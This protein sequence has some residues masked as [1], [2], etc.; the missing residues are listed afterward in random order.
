MIPKTITVSGRRWT[1]VKGPEHERLY[2][3]S[4]GTHGRITLYAGQDDYQMRDTLLHEVMHAVLRQQ[5]RKYTPKE[6][7]Y[8]TA[9]ATGLLGVLRTNPKLAEYLLS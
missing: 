9:L 5:G 3:L 2:G 4:E 6:E 1:V 7:E 8:V